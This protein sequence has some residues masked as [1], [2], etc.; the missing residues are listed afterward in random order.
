MYTRTSDPINPPID[1]YFL[2]CSNDPIGLARF[3][4]NG[5]RFSLLRDS[6]KTKYPYNAFIKAR[7]AA[8]TKGNLAPYSPNTPPITGPIINP[9]PNAAPII[10][11]F[12]ALFSSVEMS[13]I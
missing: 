8:T 7:Q 13:A 10:P 11:K 1:G 6:G 3:Q 5:L 9:S 2:N 12:C 4:L